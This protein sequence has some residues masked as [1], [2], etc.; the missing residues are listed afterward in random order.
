[1]QEE[2]SGNDNQQPEYVGPWSP[3]DEAGPPQAAGP[4][5]S[6]PVP[7]PGQPGD[8]APLSGS[9]GAPGQPAGQPGLGFGG[10]GIPAPPGAPAQPGAPTQP[11]PGGYAPP[12]GYGE[13]GH[14]SPAGSYVPPAASG[15][16]G[17]PGPAGAPGQPGPYGQ[18]RGGYGQPGYT[19]PPGGFAQP[20]QPGGGYGPPGGYGGGYGQ[21]PGGYGGYGG[22]GHPA[23]YI[24]QGPR[25]GRA[26][27]LVVYLVV[28]ALAAGIGAGAVAA[29]NHSNPS[30]SNSPSAGAPAPNNG[31]NPGGGIFGGNGNNNNN[32]N[33]VTTAQ[34]QAAENAVEPGVVDIQSNLQY[35][36]GTAE[37]TGMVISSNGLVLTNNHVIDQTTGLTATLV[38]NGQKYS[39]RWLG[40]DKTDDVSVIQLE[41]ASG[42]K[43]V[44]L[45][46]SSAVK[47]GDG[48]VAI[49][50]AGGAGGKPTVVTGSI[51]NL[52]QTITASDDLGGSETLHDMLQTDANIVEGDSGGPLVGT[53][54]RVIG[55]DT[56][57]SSGSLGNETSD[58][59]FA[60]PIN[61]ALSI[62]HEI[63]K[64]QGSS[65]VK[66]GA[67][68]FLGVLVPS[69][70]ASSASSPA[71]QRDDE[72]QQYP[73]SQ[74]SSTACLQN[75]QNSG[76]PQQIAPSGSGT[77][78][79]GDLCSTPAST[80]GITAG[81]VITAVNGKA[82]GSPDSLTAIL[83][84][85]RPGDTVSVTWVDTSGQQ[86]VGN[87]D[88]IEAPP[89]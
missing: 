16:P 89:E 78:V 14:Y 82:V 65:T 20:G 72:L 88:L 1:M 25:P 6:P 84:N 52:N 44:P 23:D 37:A 36:G 8:T 86:H 69:K 87:L 55:M 10:P 28:A 26:R 67:S 24:Q 64:G 54:N 11:G 68:G 80:A 22:Y 48:V 41:G 32:G 70:S 43:T 30:S 35:L 53:N 5:S 66:I 39:A 76:I 17:T 60:I 71:Q 61:R 45:G 31:G 42:L 12:G 81:D 21:P 2:Q 77:L 3:S 40:Y 59:G 85:Y 51:T 83:Q 9:G 63:I 34:E 57:A 15:Q 7:E 75:D 38:S 27:G 74:G 46:N 56:A 29:L 79:L 50:N 47:I 73:G 62:A 58:T 33:G 19:G 13:P 4:G 18:A 49:G